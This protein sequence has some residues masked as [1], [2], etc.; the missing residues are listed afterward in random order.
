[1]IRQFYMK[2]GLLR[3][4]E[5]RWIDILRHSLFGGLIATISVSLSGNRF[6]PAIVLFTI[7]FALLGLT[8]QILRKKYSNS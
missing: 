4:S 7:S 2:H 1:M 6:L 5:N 3:F 8:N